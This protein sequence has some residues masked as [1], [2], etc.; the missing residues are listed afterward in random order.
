M[1]TFG[2]RIL[3]TGAIAELEKQDAKALAYFRKILKKNPKLLKV[4]DNEAIFKMWLADHPGHES[5]PQ[6]IKQ[7]LA[8]VK[9]TMRKA[10]Q[11]RK[12]QKAGQEAPT[13]GT[14][15]PARPARLPAR[16]L[17]RLEDKLDQ[18][19]FF[20]KDLGEE[21]ELG[22]VIELLPEWG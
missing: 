19:L 18:C 3:L 11:E 6:N 17:E 13:K 22:R 15:A 2:V 10:R 9:S 1:A 14:P 21:D 12:G 7:L 8:N 5:V 16:D 20:A 4:R